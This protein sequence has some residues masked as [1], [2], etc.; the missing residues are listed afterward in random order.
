[1]SC[2]HVNESKYSGNLMLS[3]YEGGCVTTKRVAIGGVGNVF[4]VLAHI[5]LERARTKSRAFKIVIFSTAIFPA[6]I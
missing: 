3:E 6:L 2:C 4:N 1:M 5:R